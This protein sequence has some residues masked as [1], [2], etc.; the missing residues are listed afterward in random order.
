MPRPSKHVSPN[1]LGG[2][3]RAARQSQRLSL[4]QVAGEKYSTSL[5]SQIERNRIEPS[6]ESLQYLAERLSL[7]LDE[8]MALAQQYRETTTEE[9]KFKSFVHKRAHASH[10]LADNRPR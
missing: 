8:L 4:A 1:T 7:P 6:I 3:I 5:I 9:S 2:V 10:L